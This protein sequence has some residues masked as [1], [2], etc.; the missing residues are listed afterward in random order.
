MYSLEM[1]QKNS[2]KSFSPHQYYHVYNRGV[3]KQ[4]IFGDASDKDYL[5]KLF[6]RYLSENDDKIEKITA[7]KFVDEIEINAY[8]FMNNHFH[9]LIWLEKDT[10]AIPLF[11]KSVFTSYTMYFNKKYNRVGPLFQ[12]RYKASRITN[13]PYLIHISRYIHLNPM[14]LYKKYKYSS[15][16][17]YLGKSTQSW[18]KAE[19]IKSL[20]NSERYEEFVGNY[21]EYVKDTFNPDIAPVDKYTK[22]ERP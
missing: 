16:Q 15:Y 22:K 11:M 13:D 9:L 17:T 19:R 20:M 10:K 6:E 4:N 5:L 1:P 21:F 18:I 2:I 12:S 3:A 7:K 8:C 14:E